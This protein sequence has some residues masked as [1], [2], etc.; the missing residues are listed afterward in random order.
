MWHAQN[1]WEPHSFVWFHVL[2]RRLMVKVMMNERIRVCARIGSEC[3]TQDESEPHSF[4]WFHVRAHTLWTTL[5]TLCMRV[6]VSL[7]CV[8]SM[9]THT[10]TNTQFR[11]VWVVCLCLLACKLR[12]HTVC[13]DVNWFEYFMSPFNFFVWRT[14]RDV[15]LLNRVN[16]SCLLCGLPKWVSS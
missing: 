14:T 8:I 4:V 1:E 2:F 5:R 12:T 3:N 10:H 6:R 7:F 16:I 13:R 15:V 9:H 11:M